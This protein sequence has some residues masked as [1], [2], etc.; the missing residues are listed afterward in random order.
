MRLNEFEHQAR[1]KIVFTDG[2]ILIGKIIDYTSSQ[3]NDD[4]DAYLTFVPESG[5]LEGEDVDAPKKKFI[6]QNIQN[7]L[8][9]K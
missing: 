2:Q 7:N 3:D 6:L 8:M 4:N 9:N 1:G 5:E